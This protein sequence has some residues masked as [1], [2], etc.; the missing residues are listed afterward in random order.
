MN[1]NNEMYYNGNKLLNMQDL[2]GNK[3]EIYIVTGNRTGGKTTFFNKYVIEKFKNKGEKFCLIHRYNYELDDIADKFFNG[4]ERLFY[5]GQT[6]S[7]RKRGNGVYSDLYLNDVKCGYAVSLNN[8]DGIKKHSQMMSDV[9]HMLFDEFQSETGRYCA[10]EIKKFI[11]I[12]TSLAR[13][14]GEQS[15]YLPVYMLS[16][17][18]TLLNPYFCELGITDRLR[19]NTKFLRG[20]GW[21][22]EQNFNEN[23]K[24]AQ[25]RSAF[26]KAF[27][28]ND[29]TVYASQGVYLNDNK[30][31]IEKPQGKNTYIATIKYMGKQYA[32]R[33][34]AEQGLIYCDNKIDETY[35]YKITATTDDHEINYVMLKNN[36]RLLSLMKQYFEMGCFRFK[37]LQCK[38]MLMNILSY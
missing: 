8:A 20:N 15:K 22:L 37:N 23:A 25:S 28:K 2:E 16:N 30:C 34:Y 6:F 17:N 38:N 27:A 11:S 3:P 29:Y 19:N 24:L 5:Q 12:H 32:I 13:G 31:F 4:I 9:S 7:A 36:D 35:P 10:D 18:V 14:D 1:I 26:N 33:E 21:V